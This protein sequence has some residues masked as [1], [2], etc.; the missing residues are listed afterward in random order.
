MRGHQETYLHLPV[1]GTPSVSLAFCYVDSMNQVIK[2]AVQGR[3]GLSELVQDRRTQ[4]S[5]S[6]PNGEMLPQWSKLMGL[7]AASGGGLQWAAAV[8]VFLQEWVFKKKDR[9]SVL[10]RVLVSPDWAFSPKTEF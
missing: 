7:G 9:E 6:Q 1:T 4:T 8:I 3:S 2:L 10:W 5:N